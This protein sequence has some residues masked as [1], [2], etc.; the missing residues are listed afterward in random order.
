[1]TAAPSLYDDPL[2]CRVVVDELFAVHERL[3]EDHGVTLQQPFYR[4]E[5]QSKLESDHHVPSL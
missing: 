2:Y 3:L 4:H 5:K 1:M